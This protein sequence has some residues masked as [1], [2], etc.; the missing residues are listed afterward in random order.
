MASRWRVCQGAEQIAATIDRMIGARQ[1]Y[2]QFMSNHGRVAAL[3][4]LMDE[5]GQAHHE[6]VGGADPEWP[7]WY[8]NYMYPEILEHIGSDASVD[9]VAQWLS[10]A[11]ELHRNEAPEAPWAEFY[12]D[13][14]IRA[15]SN[16]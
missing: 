11:E 9:E 4:R 10:A 8:A 5:A 1:R 16:D 6:A 14:I 13:A 2:G 3:A 15:H 7:A 12:A